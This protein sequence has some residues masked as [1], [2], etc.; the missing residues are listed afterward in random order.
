[1][2]PEQLQELTHNE[3][4]RDRAGAVG[5]VANVALEIASIA[6]DVAGEALGTVVETTFEVIGAVIAGIFS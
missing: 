2:N 4:T 5:E 6:P 1:M 3:N